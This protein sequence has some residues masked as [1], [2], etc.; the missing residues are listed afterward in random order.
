[1]R[2]QRLPIP[3]NFLQLQRLEPADIE[4]YRAFG[5]QVAREFVD[6]IDL[7]HGQIDWTFR[8][9]T[10]TTT[11]YEGGNSAEPVYLARTEIHATLEEA[12]AVFQTTTVTA[13][14]KLQ[15]K[16]QPLVLD[17]IRLYNVTTPTPES[18]NLYQSLNWCIVNTPFPQFILKR[19]DFCYLE[20]QEVLEIQGRRAYIRAMQSIDVAGVPSLESTFNVVR[21]DLIHYSFMFLETDRHGVLELV[22]LY[23]IRLNGSMKGALGS[24]IIEKSVERHIRTLHDVEQV[25]RGHYLNHL[26]FLDPSTMPPLDSQ[27]KCEICLRSFHRSRKAQCRHCAKIVCSRKCSAVW[28]VV[29]SGLEIDVCLCIGCSKQSHRPRL[30]SNSIF[31]TETTTAYLQSMTS[32]R[33]GSSHGRTTSCATR[34]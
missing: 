29:K 4:R 26:R 19:R 28:K 13:T 12:I 18:S 3:H 1:M 15:A 10:S 24:K 14:R 25:I 30:W 21:G 16:L 27:S 7:E 33:D 20:H 11:V 2:E 9:T 31:L 34:G 32:C 6:L 17:K 8:S 23:D 5:H 22:S